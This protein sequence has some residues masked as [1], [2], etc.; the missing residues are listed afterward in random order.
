VTLA[1]RLVGRVCK[2]EE[3]AMSM[4]ETFKGLD[5]V[6]SEKNLVEVGKHMTE[7]RHMNHL[8]L[9]DLAEV[10]EPL[11]KSMGLLVEETTSSI[12]SLRHHTSASVQNIK[13]TSN[14]AEALIRRIELAVRTIRPKLLA[15]MF[16]LSLISSTAAV[17]AF[18]AWQHLWSSEVKAAKNWETME[19]KILPLLD[20][21]TKDF[22]TKILRS[23]E[24]H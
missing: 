18:C 11:A 13:E 21:K 8:A 24:Q 19:T 16:A 7:L 1:A 2:K 14:Q 12:L 10:L 17:S 6:S 9:G 4:T 23:S 15:G 5:K 3:L 22:I 20:P